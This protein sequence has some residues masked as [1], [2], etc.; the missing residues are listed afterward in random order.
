[1]IGI[2]VSESISSSRLF[3]NLLLEV[4]SSLVLFED[5]LVVFFELLH[6]GFSSVNFFCVH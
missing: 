6:L 2:K 1:M 4:F 3:S 5:S